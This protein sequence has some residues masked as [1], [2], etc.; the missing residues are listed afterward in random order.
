MC[1]Y[2][3]VHVYEWLIPAMQAMVEAVVVVV[4]CVCEREGGGGEF[5][6]VRSLLILCKQN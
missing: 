4:V 5:L 1:G 3:L 6:Q 2:L